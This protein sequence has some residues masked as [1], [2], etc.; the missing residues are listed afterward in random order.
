MKRGIILF[1][2]AVL[3]LTGCGR[4]ADPYRVD[5]VIQIPVDPTGAPA[6]PEPTEA[7]TEPE[8]APEEETSA[9]TEKPA[10]SG[11]AGKKTSGKSSGTGKTT[12]T[13]KNPKSETTSKASQTTES[14]EPLAT[15]PEPT[16]TEASH[17]EALETEPP[18]EPPSEPPTIPPAEPPAEPSYDPSGYRVGSLEYAVL[19]QINGYREEAGVPPLAMDEDLCAVASVRA[20]EISILWSHTRPDGRGYASVLTDY[21][22]AA[23]GAAEHLVY[24]S[25]NGNAAKIVSKW[26]S[27]EKNQESLL[28]GGCS[29]AGIGVY[30]SGGVTYLACLLVG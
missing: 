26:M 29:A 20:Y 11:S 4:G 15:D 27:A 23:S 6:E 28:G 16:K 9:P 2:M 25:G 18:T 17:T 5:T 12:T 14:S 1:I 10:A 8:T 13:K 21:G 19:E 3:C 22:Y 24:A 7:Q 30:R